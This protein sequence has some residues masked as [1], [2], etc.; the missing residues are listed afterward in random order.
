[1][2]VY[3]CFMYVDSSIADWVEQSLFADHHMETKLLSIFQNFD[4]LFDQNDKA[5]LG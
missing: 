4:V 1:M 3:V 2:Y 5:F